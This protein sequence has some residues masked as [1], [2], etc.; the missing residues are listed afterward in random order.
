MI[1][2]RQLTRPFATFDG[3]LNASLLEQTGE[4]GSGSIERKHTAGGFISQN[5]LL[6]AVNLWIQP[7]LH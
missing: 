7:Q 1:Q 5:G 6:L 2:K 3:Q 4:I